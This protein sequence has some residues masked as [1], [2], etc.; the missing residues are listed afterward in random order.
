MAHDASLAQLPGSQVVQCDRNAI[1]EEIVDADVVVPL[2]SRID[3]PL[4]QRAQ[5]AKLVLQF[6]VGVEG[7][8]IAEVGRG[9]AWALL[10]SGG[11]CNFA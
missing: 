5:R 11:G 3:A 6:G 7:I 4:L 9:P 2:M 10:R 8:D 1:G